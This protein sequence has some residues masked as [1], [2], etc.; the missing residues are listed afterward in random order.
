MLLQALR[1]WGALNQNYEYKK[2]PLVSNHRGYGNVD[3]GG[4]LSWQPT[5]LHEPMAMSELLQSRLWTGLLTGHEYEY[6][7]TMFQP[8]GGM[9]RISAGFVRALPPDMV[10]YNSQRPK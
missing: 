4:G 8:V 3:P 1:S 9:D 2:G 6:Q 7:M 5:D 10:K